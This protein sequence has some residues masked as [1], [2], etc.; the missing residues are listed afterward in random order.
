[1]AGIEERPLTPQ[2]QVCYSSITQ[3]IQALR[4]ATTVDHSLTPIQ[5]EN[6][7]GHLLNVAAFI[8]GAIAQEEEGVLA[9]VFIE[10]AKSILQTVGIIVAEST[11]V[12]R[13]R[14]FGDRFGRLGVLLHNSLEDAP[15]AVMKLTG[16]SGFQPHAWPENI[17]MY[18]LFLA[19]AIA[20]IDTEKK[21]QFTHWFLNTS[22]MKYAEGQ[23]QK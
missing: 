3:A 13:L 14:P 17:Q 1:M 22:P 11:I 21:Q 15:A 19:G 7:I 16:E 12:V 9:E 8:I 5:V 4:Q 10:P 6:G 20:T 2:E 23:Q 18:E